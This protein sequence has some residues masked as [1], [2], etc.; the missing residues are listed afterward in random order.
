MMAA[1]KILVNVFFLSCS[2]AT[3]LRD[4][5][6]PPRRSGEYE[7][8]QVAQVG[9]DKKR[10]QC[11]VEPDSTTIVQ[12]YKGEDLI[13]NFWTR[14]K[15]T[16]E[17]SLM[18]RIK[19][20][21][22]EDGGVYICKVSNG[23][24]QIQFN[25]TLVVIDKDRGLVNE[26]NTIYPQGGASS[27]EVVADG[28]KPFFTEVDRMMNKR[29]HHRPLGSTLRLR[30]NAGGDPPPDVQWI[31]DS[32]Q[33]L[34]FSEEESAS[35]K[36]WTLK[37]R[38]LKESDSGSY[39]CVVSNKHGFINF[40]YS[41]E[42]IGKIDTQATLIGP[43]PLNETVPIGGLATFQCKVKS[44]VKPHIR[45]LKRLD[46]D[47]IFNTNDS[48]FE[49]KDEKFLV[50][51]TDDVHPR[52]GY[53]VNKLIIK[54]VK[55]SDV[56]MY[57][58]LGTNTLGYSF[59]SAF[60]TIKTGDAIEGWDDRPRT[61]NTGYSDNHKLS[62]STGNP[63]NGSLPLII[64]IPACVAVVI[65]AVAI[66]V[67]KRRRKCNTQANA[68]AASRNTR[69]NAVPTQE[70]DN[71]TPQQPFHQTVPLAPVVT[72]KGPPSGVRSVYVDKM[73]SQNHSLD[74]YSDISSVSRCQHHPQQ[75][76]HHPHPY[77]YGQSQ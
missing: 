52:D 39:Q 60:L 9:Q 7:P 63:G 54:N 11:P 41:V 20:V 15:V 75:P 16:K 61:I 69:F 46:R 19:D 5:R 65:V 24:G 64:A 21:E 53:Y 49:V 72:Q 35:K 66:F 55:Q 22:L 34:S 10:F 76:G 27:E 1:L 8:R 71:F 51:K 56:G 26:G 77:N 12:W 33:V 36:H 14:Y 57:I 25:F 2:I 23:F 58:C 18:L 50:L 31:K 6:G 47:T 42:V 3:D 38:N 74:F 70:R 30:C 17:S 29:D 40:T 45:W 59:R 4:V 43:D 67:L 73:S 62:G 68:R 48:I 28:A 13:D 44:K 32:T 37:L